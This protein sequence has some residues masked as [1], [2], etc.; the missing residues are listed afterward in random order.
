MLT[1]STYPLSVCCGIY[2]GLSSNL[3][4]ETVRLCLLSLLRHSLLWLSLLL[5][6]LLRHSLLITLLW[7]SLLV[8][9]LWLS[10]LVSL[11]RHSLLVALLW[12]SLLVASVLL[13]LH[14]L[15][16]LC[17]TVKRCRVSSAGSICHVHTCKRHHR[18][19]ACI[20]S[21]RLHSI[22][23]GTYKVCGCHIST[24]EYRILL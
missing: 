14:H 21:C 13:I 19:G 8:S 24:S 1:A 7:L 12:H 17:H 11:L 6:A 9:L 23:L 16:L 3:T 10:L 2:P 22:S 5:I 15:L 18:T 20:G 4:Y